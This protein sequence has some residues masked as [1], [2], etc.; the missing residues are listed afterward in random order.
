MHLV[1]CSTRVCI[2]L[3]EFVYDKSVA[4][5]MTRGVEWGVIHIQCHSLSSGG[6]CLLGSLG[7]SVVRVSEIGI[8]GFSSIETPMCFNC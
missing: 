6:C 4:T 3:F 2:R 1:S 8:G 5:S 7:S